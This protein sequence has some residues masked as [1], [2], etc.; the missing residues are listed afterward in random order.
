MAELEATPAPDLTE[1]EEARRADLNAEPRSDEGFALGEEVAALIEAWEKS[2]PRGDG[3]KPRSRSAVAR[4]R[5]VAVINAFVADLLRETGPKGQ[6]LLIWRQMGTNTFS[7]TAEGAT[8][9]R[10]VVSGMQALGL[11]EVFPGKNVPEILDWGGGRT[12]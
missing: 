1:L 6:H 10:S 11:I 7:A 5:F 3:S 2:R 8:V 4:V 12:S 9:F